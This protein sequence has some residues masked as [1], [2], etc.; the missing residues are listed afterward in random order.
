MAIEWREPSPKA[1]GNAGFDWE[2]LLA[3]LRKRRGE[4]A[5][6]RAFEIRGHAGNA[7]TMLKKKYPAFDFTSRQVGEGAELFARLKPP[8][9]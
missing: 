4:W 6:I 1:T 2:P 5:M 8:A 7:T 3:E 9:S